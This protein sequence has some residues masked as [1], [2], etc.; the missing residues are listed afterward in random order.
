MLPARVPRPV[1][2][3]VNGTRLHHGSRL[4][5]TLPRGREPRRV[6]LGRDKQR[7]PPDALS[8]RRH[9]ERSAPF[10]APV[11]TVSPP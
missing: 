2:L 3:N 8:S 6:A 1:P 9:R 5:T 4:W 11:L 10:P 7:P